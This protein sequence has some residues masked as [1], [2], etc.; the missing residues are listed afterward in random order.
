MA[1]KLLRMERRRL[2]GAG[3]DPKQIEVQ[4][5][6]IFIDN[7]LHASVKDTKLKLN[8]SNA[9]SIT[10]QSSPVISPTHHSIDKINTNGSSLNVSNVPDA[11]YPSQ[12]FKV[13]L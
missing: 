10:N 6:R 3:I 11:H 9:S 8:E 4:K 1:E 7:S 12:P 2:I 5:D 13:L